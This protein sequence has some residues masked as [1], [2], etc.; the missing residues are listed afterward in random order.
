MDAG[1]IVSVGA[2]R[3]VLRET[4]AA[5]ITDLGDC[6]LLPGLI[7]AHVHLELSD[8]TPGERPTGGLEQWL[9]RMLSRTR[10]DVAELERKSADAV[11][12][13]IG[14][15]LRFGVTMVGDISR[16]SHVTRP[17][18][19]DSPL[20][21]ISFG[22]VMA[23]AQRRILLDSRLATAADAAYQTDHMRIGISPHS[24]YSIE[25]EGYRK[26]L[27]MA[28][29]LNLPL[30][31][32][33]AETRA[34][35]EFL[36]HHSGPL[37]EL[38]DAWLTWDQNVPRYSGGPIRMAW[39][40]GLLDYPSVLAHVNY[41]DDEEMRLLAA[42]KASV[43]YC[44][45]THDFFGHPPH[46]FVEM[47]RQGI[48]VAIGTD[49]CA[50]SPNLNIVDDLRLVH[51]RRPEVPVEHLWRMATINGAKALWADQEVGTLEP[52]RLADFVAFPVKGRHALRE[53]LETDVVPSW[54]FAGGVALPTPREVK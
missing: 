43:V 6:V 42:G 3:D 23:M 27:E 26:C 7:N 53:V 49:S 50:S 37:K 38:W 1:R 45:R 32:H 19:R 35:W 25:P 16:Q 2:Y 40:L 51:A 47:V 18:L 28:R 54:V 48:N 31:T 44:P 22:E 52:G 36:A 11:R 13:G 10:I 21:A 14:Q 34:E 24:P 39:E 15:C 8:C 30:A 12:L 20:R 9:T 46:G 4:A 17:V 41:C 29:A 5:Q 33:L